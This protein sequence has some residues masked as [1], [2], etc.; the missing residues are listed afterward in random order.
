VRCHE[1]Q[2]RRSGDPFVIH[3]LQV[4]E[5]V[6]EAGARKEVICAALLH[7]TSCPSERLHDEFGADVSGL[8]D[9]LTRLDADRD[10]L[11]LKLADRL[12]NMRT[13]QYLET[14]AQRQKSAQTL[15]ILVP[16]ATRLGVAD[17][18]RELSDLA[19]SVLHPT[20][21][22]TSLRALVLAAI[23]LPRTPRSRWLAEWAGELATLPTRRARARFVA[24]LV[25]AIPRLAWTLRRPNTAFQRVPARARRTGGSVLTA[26]ACTATILNGSMTWAA[27]AVGLGALTLAAGVLFART[28]DPTRRLRELIKA[29]RDTPSR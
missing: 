18:G 16:L 4:G 12:H 19:S 17:L 23:L 6:A 20:L 1:G 14:S 13:I 28:E 10:V 27:A 26:G 24:P 15:D 29:W 2:L 5:I 3:P 9:G 8:V 21:H 7:D 11:L 25:L 22:S